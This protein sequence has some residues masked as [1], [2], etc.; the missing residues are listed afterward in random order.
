MTQTIRNIIAKAFLAAAFILLFTI[1]ADDNPSFYTTIIWS[2]TS[3]VV[4]YLI[5]ARLLRHVQPEK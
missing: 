5:G 1:P 4:C 2:K 3:M